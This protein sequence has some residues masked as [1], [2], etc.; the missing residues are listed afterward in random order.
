MARSEIVVPLLD[1]LIGS[2]MIK[3]L[4]N[5]LF[6]AVYAKSASMLYTERH[7]TSVFVK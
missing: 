1:R 3:I 5:S 4:F 2:T 7:Y 6:P